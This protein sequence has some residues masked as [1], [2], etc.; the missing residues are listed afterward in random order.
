[1]LSDNIAIDETETIRTIFGNE[2]GSIIDIEIRPH[3][4]LYVVS[5][6]HEALYRSLLEEIPNNRVI[7]EEQANNENCLVF[8]LVID[9][10][11]FIGFRHFLSI[12]DF[13]CILCSKIALRK[14]MIHFF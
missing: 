7:E 10:N 9:H 5:Y 6:G 8:N 2:F 13:I 11:N 4:Y 12:F 14:L 3:G 1:L